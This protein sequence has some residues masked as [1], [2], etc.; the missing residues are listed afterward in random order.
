MEK[1]ASLSWAHVCTSLRFR[2]L[3]FL[4]ILGRVRNLRITAEQMHIT[5][6]AATKILADIEAIFGARLFERLP[7]D[8]RP[9]DLGLFVLRYARAMMVEGSR[10]VSE[11]E[12]LKSGGHGHLTVGAISGS[13][14]QLMTAAIQE[15]HQLRPLLVVKVLEQSSDQLIVWLEEKKLDIMIGRFTETRHQSLYDYEMLA[16]ETVWV[17][18]SPDHPL[19]AEPDGHTLDELVDWPWILYPPGTALRQLFEE[20]FASAGLIVPAGT[21]ETPSF[22]STF[23][24]LQATRMLSLQPQA[25]VEKYVNKGVLGRIPVPMQDTMPNYGLI[26]R[27]GEV[28]SQAMLE[29]TDILRCVAGRAASDVQTGSNC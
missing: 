28:P 20:A 18:S 21:V 7:R 8:M 27:K 14:A 26:T 15:I 10:F 4:D 29:F 6:P 11:F 1:S 22:F 25:I 12:A 9:S 3:Q 5:Q 19:L 16:G 23:E 17:V 2:H 13:A 24:L